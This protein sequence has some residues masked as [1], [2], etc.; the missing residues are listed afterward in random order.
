MMKTSRWP[1][2]MKANDEQYCIMISVII[3]Y[4]GVSNFGVSGLNPNVWPSK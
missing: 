1:I 4:I 2:Q 3:L